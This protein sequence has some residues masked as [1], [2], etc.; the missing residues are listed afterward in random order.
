[1]IVRTRVS[2]ILMLTVTAIALGCSDESDSPGA[3]TT[4]QQLASVPVS[5]ISLSEI[6]VKMNDE[7]MTSVQQENYKRSLLGKKVIWN[8]YVDQVNSKEQGEWCEVRISAEDIY[9]ELP[10]FVKGRRRQGGRDNV[11]ITLTIPEQFAQGASSASRGQHVRFEGIIVDTQGPRR[12][13]SVV[14]S[15]ARI[16]R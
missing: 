11:W 3:P 8:G 2:V 5:N 7:R 13:R 16:L 4:R 1:M 9:S 14:L 15:P 6:C 12:L 10:Q